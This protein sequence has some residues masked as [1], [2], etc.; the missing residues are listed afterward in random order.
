MT[1]AVPNSAF[2]LNDHAW[3]NLFSVSITDGLHFSLMPSPIRWRTTKLLSAFSDRF[4][5]GRFNSSCVRY[6]IDRVSSL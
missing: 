4:G 5:G 1:V 6:R 3:A 2:A